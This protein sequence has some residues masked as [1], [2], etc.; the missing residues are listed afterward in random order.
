MQ[1]SAV[2]IL[3]TNIFFPQDREFVIKN[4]KRFS[5]VRR[6]TVDLED[7]DKILRV[8]CKQLSASQIINIV[9]NYGYMCSELP[10]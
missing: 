5:A 8:E 9:S 6:A 10:E 7:R 4:L 1:T 3:K 2:H